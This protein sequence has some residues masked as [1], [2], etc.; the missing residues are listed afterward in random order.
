MPGL[1]INII[2]FDIPY[3]ANYGGAIDIFYKIKALRENNVQIILH[4]FQYNKPKQQIL[5]TLCEKVFYYK[6]PKGIKYI[7]SNLPYIV[8]TRKNPDLLKNLQG[9]NYPILFEGLHDCGFLHSE[10]L[11]NRIKLVRTHNIEHQYYKGLQKAT[12]SLTNKLYF[13]LESR[14]LR[15][16]ESILKHA[17]S[18]FPISPEDTK[19]FATNFKPVYY[20][21]AFHS[22]ETVSI[23]PGKGKYFLYHGN[24]D[25]EENQKAVSFLIN[26]VFVNT[27]TKLIVAGKNTGSRIAGEMQKLPNSQLISNPSPKKIDELIENAHACILPTFQATGLKLKLLISLFKSRHV[28]VNSTMVENTG[29]EELCIVTNSAKDFVTQINQIQNIEFTPEMI[30]N[31]E[32]TLDNFSNKTNGKKL[33]KILRSIC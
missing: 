1:T 11:K 14:K 27:N 7:F 29:L 26:Q 5:E 18:I 3:P 12:K 8:I 19:Y 4:C 16:F 22:C 25:V 21:P 23:K 31:R 17:T 15:K 20:I 28:I 33:T 30:E 6:R 24:L 10:V 2:S 32:K 13:A 9:N